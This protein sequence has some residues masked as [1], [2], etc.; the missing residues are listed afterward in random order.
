M[1]TENIVLVQTSDGHLTPFDHNK[2]ADSLRKE[3]SLSDEDVKKATRSVYRKCMQTD[4]TL[5][6]PLIRGFILDYILRHGLTN[7]YNEYKR[8]GLPMAEVKKIWSVQGDSVHENA[9]IDAS[10]PEGIHKHV[11]DALSK[12]AALTLLPSH[13]SD[14]HNSGAFH[15]HD[16]EYFF[17]RQFCFDSDLRFIFRYGLLPD[18]T[19]ANMPVAAPAKNAEV[20]VLHAAKALG[21]MQCMCAGGQGFQNFLTFLAPYFEGLEYQ[22]IKQLMQMF[23]YEMSQMMVA[24]GAQAVFSSVQLTPGVPK[25]WRDKPVV[26]KGKVWDRTY[27]TS[28]LLTTPRR[29]YSEFEREVRLA[30]LAFMEVLE[31]GDAWGKPFSFPKPEVVLMKEFQGEAWDQPLTPL[32]VNEPTPSYKDLYHAAFRVIAK[33]GSIYLE[34]QLSAKENTISCVQCCAYRFERSTND[35]EF[36]DQLNFKDGKHFSLGS[37]QVVSLNL[38]RAAYLGSMRSRGEQELARELLTNLSDEDAKL[39]CT[40]EE[41]KIL[42]DRAIEIFKIKRDA[43]KAQPLP[44]ARQTLEGAPPFAELD[45]LSYVIGV[46]GLNEAV[47]HLTGLQMHESPDAW[48]VG[49]RIMTELEFYIQQKA[50]DSGLAL[51][52]ARTPAET[53]AQRFAVADLLDERF[54]DYTLKVVKGNVAEALQQIDKTRDLPV[55]YSNGTHLAVNAPVS[56]KEKARLEQVFF[57]IVGGGNIFHIF[58]NEI[59]PFFDASV[60]TED[61]KRVPVWEA[62]GFD[63][64]VDRLMDYV[65]DLARNSRLSYIKI[66][67]DTT[68][69]KVCH[70]VRGGLLDKCQD[71]GSELVDHMALV[72]GY[73]GNV[74]SFNSAKRQEVRDRHRYSIKEM[75]G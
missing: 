19:G 61:L 12:E 60:V 33:H 35:S 63:A 46:V 13:L 67:K 5:T 32:Y 9:N 65:L 59:N 55:E 24:R 40:I 45:S 72:T 3:T 57:P 58:L 29:T 73:V 52:L 18:G 68:I 20:A 44:F 21:C 56:L 10:N 62:P 53:T 69:C 28:A 1:K 47:Q 50:F 48:K 37:I 30:F 54:R 6:G 39:Y 11:A 2:I 15:I 23:I 64:L 34:N 75:V 74:A 17:T 49:I 51:A 71:C 14:L 41:L 26:Y 25:I 7:T 4:D 66:S 31:Q 70:S 27:E 38:P 22:E 43:I 36:L 16:L 8:V 42:V